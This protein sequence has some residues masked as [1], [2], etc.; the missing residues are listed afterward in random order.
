MVL[1]AHFFFAPPPQPQPP[2]FLPFPL[3]Q[4]RMLFSQVAEWGK[5]KAEF[6]P[7]GSGVLTC[8]Q[9]PTPTGCASA[10]ESDVTFRR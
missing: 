2:V 8:I 4:R 10:S 5:G 6:I 7:Q 3:S 1:V 9:S